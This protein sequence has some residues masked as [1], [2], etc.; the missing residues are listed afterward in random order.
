MVNSHAALHQLISIMCTEL[1][2]DNQSSYLQI[3]LNA[4][5]LETMQY[6]VEI[7]HFSAYRFDNDLFM[8]VYSSR[9]ELKKERAKMRL[10]FSKTVNLK[11]KRYLTKNKLLNRT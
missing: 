6:A 7:N 1:K 9:V 5:Y 2:V 11:N 8:K 3:K 4:I 10:R